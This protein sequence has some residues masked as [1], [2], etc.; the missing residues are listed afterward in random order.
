MKKQY[1]CRLKEQCNY[2]TCHRVHF[3]MFC[4]SHSRK[5]HSNWG[6]SLVQTEHSIIRV[7]EYQSTLSLDTLCG[8]LLNDYHHWCITWLITFRL[9]ITLLMVFQF[10]FAARESPLEINS[11][12][13]NSLEIN[14]HKINSHKINSHKINSHET[15]SP[16]INSNFLTINSCIP[17]RIV[18]NHKLSLIICRR[19]VRQKVRRIQTNSRLYIRMFVTILIQFV[20]HFVNLT[21]TT[22]IV[23]P[24]NLGV[25]LEKI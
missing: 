19:Q 11:L 16:E 3:L 8:D 21:W 5:E 2:H 20:T 23:V 22:Q 4:F 7:A 14:S 9:F 25:Y 12:E 10:A 24:K 15:N 13:I 17:Y 6:N 18:A 1:F